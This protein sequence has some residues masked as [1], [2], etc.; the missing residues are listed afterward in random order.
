MDQKKIFK[1][2]EPLALENGE[3]LQNI[4]IAYQTFG[5][6]IDE[7]KQVVVV[8]HALSGSSQVISTHDDTGWWDSVFD[9]A[10]LSNQSKNAIICPNLLGSCYG[11]SGPCSTNP[12]T[13]RHFGPDFPWI[14]TKD[15]VRAARRLVVEHLNIGKP[16]L[17]IGGSLGGMVAL[18]WAVDY[19]DD[20]QTVIALAAPDKTNP[21]T[22]AL[23]YIQRNI[24]MLDPN[25]AQG[26]YTPG[27]E[28][29]G[30]GIARKLGVV[31]YR[32]DNEFLQRFQDNHP[33]VN[34]ESYL[35]HH[36][37]KFSRRFDA[38]SYLR[39]SQAMDWYDL[40]QGYQNL[41]A[42]LERIKAAIHLLYFDT[43]TLCP[44]YQVEA[45]A[46][47][48]G[49]VN[50]SIT[51][52]KIESLYGHDGFLLEKETILSIVQPLFAQSGVS[53]Y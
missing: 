48:L 33:C 51:S 46:N 11:S 44:C 16:L 38:N 41:N 29:A 18:Q 9:L 28:L 26:R 42:A 50:K 19:P 20:V 37:K 31:T 12:E 36:A 32:S 25:W 2:N 49:T 39:L 34:V 14:N 43:D 47:L 23:R 7:A 21:K 52:H 3:I 8:L 35:D 27:E 30:L 53:L 22:R 15:M 1:S 24:V 17:L 40:S 45:L 13:G 5:C 6:P 4:E 10:S